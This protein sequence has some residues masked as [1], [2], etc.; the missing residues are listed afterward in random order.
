M[1]LSA[2]R[3]ACLLLAAT[4]GAENPAS[5]PALKGTPEPVVKKA[6]HYVVQVR[7]VEIDEQ[8]RE[9]LLGEPKLQTAGGN[10]G[11][12]IDHPDGRRFEFTVRLTDRLGTNGSDDLIPAKPSTVNLVETRSIENIQKKLD[13]KIELNFQQQPRREILKEIAKRAGFNIA[14]DPESVREVA[15]QMESLVDLK[16]K[17]ETVSTTLDRL[18]EPL[19]LGFAVKHDVVLIAAQDKLLPAPEEFTVKT[20]D[21]A[22]LVNV[23]NGMPDFAPLIERI[24][25]T[26]LPTSWERKEA[27]ATIRPFN[28]TLSIVVRQTVPGHA[29]IERLLEKAR[30]ELPMTIPE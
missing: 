14:I 27:T 18:I 8:G 20:Y 22:D 12:S 13:Q 3:S 4:L 24:K 25:K 10:A 21:V 19:N 7:L 5:G 30:R 16:V 23:G 17:N 11:L 9:T 29:A 2:T 1:L 15:E 28:S 26:V 6:R